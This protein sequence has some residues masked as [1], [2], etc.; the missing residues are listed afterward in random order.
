V[1]A[2]ETPVS[3]RETRQTDTA[4]LLRRA[5]QMQQ[6]PRPDDQA[7]AE[8][9][10]RTVLDR[11]PSQAA[12]HVGLSR[13]ASYLYALGLDETPERLEMA[14]KEAE[15]AIALDARDPRARA[16]LVRALAASNRMTPALEE[17]HR[18]VADAPEAAEAHLALCLVERLKG[19]EDAALAACRRAGDLAPDEPLVL[20][21]LAAVLRERADYQGAMNLL[22]QAADLDHESA[23][24][25]LDA[26]ATL[27]KQ[28]SVRAASNMYKIILERFPFARTR[29]LQGAAALRLTLGDYE[30]AL[31]LYES[32]DLPQNASLP[33]LLSLYGRGYALFRLERAAEAEYFLSLLIERVPPDYDGP[34]RGREVL[35]LAYD[36]LVRYFDE[37]GRGDRAAELLRAATAR[38]QAPTR[39]ARALA[40]RQSEGRDAAAAPGRLEQAL[41]RSDPRE[42]PLELA[43]TALLLARLRSS[44]GRKA[45]RPGSTTGQAIRLTAERVAASPLG[46]VHYRMAR[47][48][49]LSRD[50]DSSLASLEK[51]RAGGFLPR[52]KAASEKDFVILHGRTEFQTLL[53]P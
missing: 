7:E 43:E 8:R 3:P 24:P 18:A 33:T 50:V 23:L 20:T 49:A 10:C 1:S 12:A 6:R 15:A 16:A 47:A 29:A 25:Q 39:L 27:Q 52:D 32:V 38:P 11:D 2:E 51:A 21:G 31:E 41:L 44:D 34:A 30:G 35:Y 48:F 42:D 13:V 46:V 22:G 28:N 36:D 19:D 53:N 40:L 37:R 14:R 26:A 9:L 4:S 45:V 17:A 5:L